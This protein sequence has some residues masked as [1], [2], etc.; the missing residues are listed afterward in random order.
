MPSGQRGGNAP[1]EGA[2]TE[3]DV[4]LQAE[5]LAGM[6]DQGTKPEDIEEASKQERSRLDY[7]NVKSEL[8]PA[9][10]DLLNQDR[11]PWEYRPLIKN[12]FQAI[13]PTPGG[14]VPAGHQSNSSSSRPVGP[15]PTDKK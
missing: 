5:K 12:Y 8:R 10:K 6:K 14:G 3:L 9:Q 7:R 15:T 4:K 1:R 13:R 2:P 11:I